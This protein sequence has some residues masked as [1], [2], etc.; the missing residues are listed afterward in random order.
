MDISGEA[1]LGEKRSKDRRNTDISDIK[2]QNHTL[3]SDKKPA[4]LKTV[5]RVASVLSCLSNGID[6]VTD[7]ARICKIH[8]ST[9]HRLLQALGE[10]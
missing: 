7:I 9:A 3:E 6:S 5:F 4:A 1:I 8:K 2:P 10:A